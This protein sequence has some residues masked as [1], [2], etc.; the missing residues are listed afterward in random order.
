MAAVS[1]PEGEPGVV[2][3]GFENYILW[4]D[5]GGGFL[6]HHPSCR[7]WCWVRFVGKPGTPPT[8]HKLTSGGKDD[9]ASLTVEGS[10]LCPG[11]CGAHGF[12]RQGALVPA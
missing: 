6:W 12:I 3:L 10:L 5:D 1:Y 7:A 2:A 4:D 11:G 9:P 8:G